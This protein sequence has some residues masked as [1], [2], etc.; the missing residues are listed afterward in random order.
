MAAERGTDTE[1]GIESTIS[2]QLRSDPLFDNVTTEDLKKLVYCKKCDKSA[3]LCNLVTEVGPGPCYLLQC[4]HK[5]SERSWY[6]CAVCKKRF[7]RRQLGEHF[8][9]V[10]HCGRAFKAGYEPT[11]TTNHPRPWKSAAIK[12]NNGEQVAELEAVLG[13]F[14]ED[15][16]MSPAD[17]EEENDQVMMPMDDDDDSAVIT[18]AQVTEAPASAPSAS[19]APAAA[20][21]ETIII[22][23]TIQEAYQQA[24]KPSK[25][26]ITV[27]FQGQK[28]M[29]FYHGAEHVKERGGVQ[30]LVS[31]CFRKSE[32]QMKSKYT[33]KIPEAEWHFDAFIQYVS[34]TDRQRKRNSNILARLE[35]HL[36]SESL[37][38]A[39]H[40]LSYPQL[41]RVYGSSNQHSL[42]NI[43]PIPTVENLGGIAYTNILHVIRY[44]MA[45]N[46]ELDN[47]FLKIPPLS[48]DGTP[49]PPQEFR[50]PDNVLHITESLE[51][52]QWMKELHEAMRELMTPE[53][54][55]RYGDYVGLYWAVDWR[56]GFGANR[57]KQNRKSTNA[58]TFS[59]ATPQARINSLSNTLPIALGLKKN[60]NWPEVEHRF[61]RDSDVLLNGLQPLIVYHGGLKKTIPVFVRRLACLTDKVER[62]DYTSTLSCTSKY[63]R[64]FGKIILFEPPTFQVDMIKLHL[65]AE[66]TGAKDTTIKEFGWS[67]GLMDRAKNGGRFPACVS[68]RKKNVEW[69]HQPIYESLPESRCEL[70][71]NWVLDA[72]TKV[73][74]KFAAP[75]EYPP[76]ARCLDNCPVDPPEGRDAG[77]EE[78]EFL[79]LDFSTMKQAARFAFYHS[80]SPR[81]KGWTKQHCRAYLRA[82]G[83]NTKQ[84]DLIY[85]AAAR[86]H[87]GEEEVD[88]NSPTG[89]GSYQFPAAWVGDMPLRLFIEMLMHLLF[90]G[91]AESNFKLCNLYLQKFG[92][93]V[94]TFKKTTQELLKVLTKFNLQWL[95]AFPFS[96]TKKTKYTTGTWV[97][98]NWLAWVRISKVVYAYS[99]KRGLVDERLGCNDLVRMVCSFTAIVGRVLSHAGTS[100]KK[101]M[102][103]NVLLREFLSA[104]TE[105]DI[106]T[107][108]EAMHSLGVGRGG[109]ANDTTSPGDEKS[110]D[111]WWLK[112]NYVSVLNLVPTMEQLGPLINYWD[113][114][115]KG[116]RYIQ[117]IK[118]HIPRGVRDGGKFFVR[119]VPKTK[120]S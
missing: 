73:L 112:S 115:G 116:E 114:G 98:E 89:I 20:A 78:L 17:E 46:T 40:I 106:R 1:E 29:L 83:I 54:V 42:W 85:E 86:A 11:S 97:S 22:P 119:Y 111:Q 44:W 18:V 62:A 10:R 33:A 101:I 12:N 2:T 103:V 90:L 68:C 16:L 117:E 61:R 52:K 43:L 5:G 81:N 9:G 91:V 94:E 80:K 74:L 30:Y 113:G 77:V 3:Y 79:E 31:R 27:S 95:L 28:A 59:L 69:L 102:Q 37:F 108:Y 34:M 7:I 88:Y 36:L 21:A 93:P 50:V 13:C 39:T 64:C 14:L 53:F 110:K 19:Q 56:D 41:N 76:K 23:T 70:C 92:R 71:A 107:R 47:C 48:T 96:G 65:E 120:S 82:C 49:P 72:G 38:Q 63:H 104:V 26:D 57:T 109:G 25:Q 118:P 24:K 35:H 66:N 32:F 6:L 15:I 75:K 45:F 8:D 100:K 67:C 105:L 84:Q 55:A 4:S 99:A 87:A 60:D 58:W 51:F